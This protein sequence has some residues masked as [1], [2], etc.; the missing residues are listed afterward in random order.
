M[1]LTFAAITSVVVVAEMR[2]AIVHIPSPPAVQQ[3]FSS[4][5]GRPHS[6]RSGRHVGP[7]Q[8]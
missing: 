2:E 4:G 1:H 5:F 8:T 7:V 6:E 3:N